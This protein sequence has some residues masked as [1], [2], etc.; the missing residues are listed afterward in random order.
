MENYIQKYS[1]RHFTQ[2]RSETLIPFS[3]NLPLSFAYLQKSTIARFSRTNALAR[4]RLFTLVRLSGRKNLRSACLIARISGRF[5]GPLIPTGELAC[6]RRFFRGARCDLRFPR[7][8]RY[9][10]NDDGKTWR[11]NE[12]ENSVLDATKSPRLPVR[13]RRIE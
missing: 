2:T 9:F 6:V 4:A 11:A 10:D 5:F 12:A 7:I 3:R 1:K 8:G 13:I